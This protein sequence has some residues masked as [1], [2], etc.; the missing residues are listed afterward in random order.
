MYVT[1]FYIICKKV[2][3]NEFLALRNPRSGETDPRRIWTDN[4]FIAQHFNK[5]KYAINA[6]SE[7]LGKPLYQL[8][9]GVDPNSVYYIKHIIIDSDS[10]LISDRVTTEA[11]QE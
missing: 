1:D 10:M 4:L 5:P 6:L 11:P 2:G 9:I 7:R 3:N 8:R